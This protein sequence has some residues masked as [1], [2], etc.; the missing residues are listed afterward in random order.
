MNL[1]AEQIQAL[2]AGSEPFD[3]TAFR[4]VLDE[5][6]GWRLKIEVYE[7]VIRR[8]LH[9]NRLLDKPKHEWHFKVWAVKDSEKVWLYT[10]NDVGEMVALE[11]QGKSD[12]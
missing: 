7:D 1:S 3:I 8:T 5:L 2:A 4:K 12:V 6:P 10:S 9:A 11:M